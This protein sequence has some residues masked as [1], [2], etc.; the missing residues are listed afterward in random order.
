MDPRS[1]RVT[2]NIL[3]AALAIAILAVLALWGLRGLSLISAALSGIVIFLVSAIGLGIA[4]AASAPLR[5]G[6]ARR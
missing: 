1:H 3:R 2:T 6:R 4:V 5:A